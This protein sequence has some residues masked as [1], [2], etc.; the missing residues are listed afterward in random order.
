MKPYSQFALFGRKHLA[1]IREKQINN[2][3]VSYLFKYKEDKITCRK[4]F[5]ESVSCNCRLFLLLIVF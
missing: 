2:T 1:L 4:S 3:A 5:I